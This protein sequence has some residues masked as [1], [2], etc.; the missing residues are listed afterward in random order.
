[1]PRIIAGR[2]RGHRVAAPADN[3]T[4]PTSD[5]V[6]EALFSALVSWAG[7]TGEAPEAALTG[8]SF[9]DL[10]A[11][12]AAIAL[13][14]AS[15]GAA[16][17]LA[18]EQNRRTAD[19]ARGNARDT[20]LAV[21]VECAEVGRFL[22]GPPTR[23]FDIVW[24]D[25]PYDVPNDRLAG[26]LRTCWERGWLA[27]DGLLVVERDRRS[28]EPTWPDTGTEPGAPRWDTWQRRYGETV[29]HYAE[30][31]PGDP[32]PTEEETS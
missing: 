4:R 11:G 26:V 18:V 10:Y 29:I 21:R 30:L 14:A 8:F 13:E 15:R 31:I 23:A 27:P 24:A 6:R 20:A 1:M 17:V 12:S 28:G 5:R 32:D 7:R 16:P 3:A 2:A 9:L 19:L 22:A 25:P